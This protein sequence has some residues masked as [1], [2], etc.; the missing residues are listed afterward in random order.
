MS[1]MERVTI[2]IPPQ[3]RESAARLAE[4]EGRSFSAFISS[5]VED[6]IRGLLLDEWLAEQAAERGGWDE[7]ELKALAEETG[8]PY[9]PPGRPRSR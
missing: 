3:L 4:R 7:E 2:S 5:A 1:T 9:L 8:I 6:H